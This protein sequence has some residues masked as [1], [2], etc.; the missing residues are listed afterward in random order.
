MVEKGL[1]W[2]INQQNALQEPSK[3]IQEENLEDVS[4]QE[5]AEVLGGLI[6]EERHFDT[7]RHLTH[8]VLGIATTIQDYAVVW[9]V[10]DDEGLIDNP[11]STYDENGKLNKFITHKKTS[12]VTAFDF[13]LQSLDDVFEKKEERYKSFVKSMKETQGSSE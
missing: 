1:K 10:R 4:L 11:L 8:Y 13:A 5:L 2:Y 6:P 7:I 9:E 12:Y 3:H